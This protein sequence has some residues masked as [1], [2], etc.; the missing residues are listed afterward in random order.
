MAA[1]VADSA[2]DSV[3]VRNDIKTLFA[4]TLSTSPIK[5]N[6]VF[7]KGPKSLSKNPPDCPILCN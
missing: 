4:N 6:S 5:G 2:A 3:L 1:S 7:S